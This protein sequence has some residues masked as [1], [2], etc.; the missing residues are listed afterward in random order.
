MSEGPR[1]IVLGRQEQSV[2]GPAG[3]PLTFKARGEQTGGLLTAIENEIAPG[4]VRTCVR[5]PARTS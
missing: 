1:P 3:G 5:A 2:Q 4:R